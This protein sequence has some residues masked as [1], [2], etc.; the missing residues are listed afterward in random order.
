MPL[1]TASAR[2]TDYNGDVEV[3]QLVTA[4]YDA[5]HAIDLCCAA[6]ERHNQRTRRQRGLAYF[7][8]LAASVDDHGR[9]HRHLHLPLALRLLRPR[10]PGGFGIPRPPRHRG[11]CFPTVAP[12][13]FSAAVPMSWA[14]SFCLKR[15]PEPPKL[16]QLGRAKGWHP[17]VRTYA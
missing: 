13:S 16:E 14:P 15:W 7:R 8:L 17:G 4:A 9:R 6:V 1:F 3:I 5:R 11:A 10:R 2:A 12:S